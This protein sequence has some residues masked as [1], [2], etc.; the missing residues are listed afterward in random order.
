MISEEMTATFKMDPDST[1]ATEAGLWTL[2]GMNRAQ[3]SWHYSVDYQHYQEKKTGA[4]CYAPGK[5]TFFLTYTNTI[6]IAADAR[7]KGCRYSVT[8][9]HEKRHVS[10]DLRVTKDWIPDIRAAMAR[11]AKDIRY[12]PF[13][14]EKAQE[15][16]DA[17]L[18][19][20]EAQ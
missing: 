1:M 20:V 9:A 5:I 3:F 7:L 13:E 8:K 10:T 2:G 17:F 18:R 6:Y 4:Y 14:K 11:G 15:N 12:I 16:L 19:P